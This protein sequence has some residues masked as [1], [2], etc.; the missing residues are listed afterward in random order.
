MDCDYEVHAFATFENALASRAYDKEDV[1]VE[2]KVFKSCR[3][4]RN[5]NRRGWIGLLLLSAFESSHEVSG[6]RH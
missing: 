6:W 2:K 4:G 3:S 5:S 1:E